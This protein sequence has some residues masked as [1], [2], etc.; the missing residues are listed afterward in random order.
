VTSALQSGHDMQKFV[1][2]AIL[3]RTADTKSY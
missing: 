2:K 3:Q 1:K